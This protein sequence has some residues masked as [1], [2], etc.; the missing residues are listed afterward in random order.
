MVYDAD[1]QKDEESEESG[2]KKEWQKTKWAYTNEKINNSIFRQ[3]VFQ[4]SH[5][6]KKQ[7]IKIR[8]I[9]EKYRLFMFYVLHI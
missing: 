1:L 4:G 9:E 2:H 7:Q 6:K 5:E 3:N 8:K